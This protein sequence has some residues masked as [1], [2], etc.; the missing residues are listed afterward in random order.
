MVSIS[1]HVR[2]NVPAHGRNFFFE[3]GNEAM[4][5][6]TSHKSQTKTTGSPPIMLNRRHFIATSLLA[7]GSVLGM[8]A[9]FSACGGTEAGGTS[10]GP[11]T[12]TIM[13]GN[14][15][16]DTGLSP[17]WINTFNKEN[18]SI[19][20]KR[21]DYD[22]NRLS[23]MLAAGTPPDMIRTPGG[24]EITSLAARG[25]ALD[26]TPYFARSTLL[27]EADL[28]PI[29][30]L[31][32]WDGKV[33]G[34]GARYGMP[35]DWSQDTMYWIDTAV[36][37]QAKIAYPSQTTPLSYD[38]LLD[39]GK[40]LTVREGGKIKV[41]GLGTNWDYEAQ[42][43]A[44]LAQQGAS[45]YQG[46]DLSKPD[47]TQP[48]VRRIFQW[49]VDWAQAHVGD[50]P[51]DPGSDWSG[52]LFIAKRYAMVPAGMWFGGY[53]EGDTPA[54]R[55]RAMLIPAPQWGTAKRV[56]TCYGGTGFYISKASK[57]PDQTWKFFEWYMG[58]APAEYR[59]KSSFGLSPLKR[60]FDSFPQAPAYNKQ[61]Y[62]VQKAE[63]P[64]FQTL[65]FTPYV[66]TGAISNVLD[67][68]ITPAMRGQTS[69][70]AA[71]QQVNQT[72]TA[73]SQQGKDLIG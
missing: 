31:Y 62:D 47:F 61:A 39:L 37:D 44:L 51:L 16:V 65:Q 45:L 36:F 59:A 57:H 58:G 50:S 27:K 21:I 8:G 67:T 38:E 11:I 15:T 23:A 34:Q 54:A 3:R 41:Y 53:V 2:K 43:L 55:P 63:L 32:R 29:N 5:L 20:V 12:V 35:H 25:L 72:I 66:G 24:S 68:Q 60:L 40:R 4:G 7:T 52:P 10:S 48:E 22:K 69:L 64:Y 30:D 9:T 71:L 49:Y 14:T 28:L 73:L 33:Q 18:T 1:M 42:L 19:I 13:E 56:S 17:H 26:L 70:D 46:G 6:S